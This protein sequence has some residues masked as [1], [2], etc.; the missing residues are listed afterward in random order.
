MISFLITYNKS[1]SL[2]FRC[3]DSAGCCA[4]KSQI[5]KV[6][7]SEPVIL[8]FLSTKSGIQYLEREAQNHTSCSCQAINDTIK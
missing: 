2:F 7:K 5:C 6:Q 1:L 3:D 4:D 8:V